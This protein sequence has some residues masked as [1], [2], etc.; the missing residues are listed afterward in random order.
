[1]ISMLFTLSVSPVTGQVNH[2]DNTQFIL[3][4]ATITGAPNTGIQ[5]V[6]AAVSEKKFIITVEKA[7]WAIVVF[8]ITWILL[9]YMSRILERLGERRT[10]YRMAIKGVI[11]VVRIL[12][13][14]G[15]LYFI[16]ED[17]IAPPWATLFTLLASAGVAV[18]FASQDILKNIFGGIMIL[19]D[20]PFQV[21]DKVEIGKY[22]GEIVDIGLR[23]VRLVTPDDS[24]V[25][26]PNTEIVNNSVSNANSGES[27]CQ[28][29]AEFYLPVGVDLAP[30]RILAYR[31]A[32]ISKYVYLK[33]PIVV[34]FL[35]EQHQGRSYIKM[36]LKAYV[37]DLRYEFKFKSDMTETV[38]NELQRQG[39][40]GMMVHEEPQEA[41]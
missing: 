25:T 32:A 21:G 18:G 22:Y 15:V 26:V 17:I 11:P 23:T 13:W 10:R 5:S 31:A 1:M 9:K 12:I 4:S 8:I 19:F 41:V 27:N 3:D 16:L 33:K 24:L 28:V 2:Q 14:T 35:N 6:K 39:I 30:I 34:I 7:F 20:R 38:I 29:V 36:R 40:F 37:L